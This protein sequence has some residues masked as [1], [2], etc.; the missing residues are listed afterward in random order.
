MSNYPRSGLQ[1]SRIINPKHFVL[2][3]VG[4]TAT[5]KTPI[6]LR[7]ADKLDTEIISADSRQIYKLMDIGTAK[8]SIED[9]R[10]VKH[11][12]VDELFPDEE[13]NAGEF[14]KKGRDVVDDIL[15]RKKIPLVV[16]GS[17]LYV[18]ALI[19]GFFD[20]PSADKDIREQLYQR[21]AEGGGE[22]LLD[23][24]RAIDA[25]AASTM[26]P[27]NTRRIIRALV[28]YRVTGIPISQLRKFKTK[29]NFIPILA[30]LNWDRKILYERINRRVD[31][32]IEHG[33]VDEVK[34]L[35]DH[36]YTSTLNAFQTVGYKEVFD[37]ID[38][39]ID[40]QRMI[41]L[42]KQNSRRYAK[43]QLTWFRQDER[44]RWFDLYDGEDFG[45]I[46][47]EIS[48]YYFTSVGAGGFE[49]PTSWSRTKRSSRA[50]PRPE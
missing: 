31:L 40:Y 46:A 23:E 6:S 38:G 28:V 44:I 50:E 33:L 21:L 17:G 27:T 15:Q 13:F 24:L 19:D 25:E 2:V 43:R 11:Y 37:F 20:G 1:T 42:I 22:K 45:K 48:K 8:P 39:K 14:G 34:R 29:I 26:L 36:G 3:L 10:K 16:G 5:G 35:R 47:L 12:F 7:I 18:Q 30:G 4:P 32:M 49:P 9:R 41:D